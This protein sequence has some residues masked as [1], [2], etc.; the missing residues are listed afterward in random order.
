[1]SRSLLC[2]Y[3]RM[4]NKIVTANRP[5]NKSRVLSRTIEKSEE[6]HTRRGNVTNA[7][8]GD[9][10]KKQWKDASRG[11]TIAR[12]KQSKQMYLPFLRHRTADRDAPGAPF[13]HPRRPHRPRPA[14]C[15]VGNREK[16]CGTAV[17]ARAL[18][19]TTPTTCD[20]DASSKFTRGSTAN[21]YCSNLKLIARS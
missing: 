16:E 7:C 14:P 11:S 17:R 6:G 12:R 20:H 10:E 15:R 2:F 18:N 21:Y 1:M 13:S 19:L 3:A 9:A 4:Y 5:A 8:R